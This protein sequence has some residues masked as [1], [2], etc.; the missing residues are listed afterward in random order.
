MWNLINTVIWFAI[1]ISWAFAILLLA[2]AASQYAHLGAFQELSGSAWALAL[3][4]LGLALLGGILT[5]AL[6]RSLYKPSDFFEHAG[7]AARVGRVGRHTY[8]VSIGGLRI[9]KQFESN[10]VGFP[11]AK[12]TAERA[13]HRGH[14]LR[15]LAGST[16]PRVPV[17]EIRQLITD[18]DPFVVA[19]PVRSEFAPQIEALLRDLVST[20]GTH[21]V[22]LWRVDTRG[23]LALAAPTV[24]ASE[25]VAADSGST[26]DDSGW[27]IF[28]VYLWRWDGGL[29]RAGLDVVM[30]AARQMPADDVDVEA[31]GLITPFDELC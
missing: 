3:H 14:V 24:T 21:R 17:T 25:D 6:K 19:A 30:Q 10:I 23:A 7:R 9:Y 26:D 20:V 22:E 11:G 27:W 1:F 5:I 12:Q 4:G 15:Q 8:Q 18:M 28:L 31:G 16:E 29:A 13:A 2:G